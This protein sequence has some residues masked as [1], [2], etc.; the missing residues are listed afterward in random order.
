M[1]VGSIIQ[2][3][4][5]TVPEGYLVCDG[6]AV[7]RND[8]AGL[9]DVIGITFGPGDGSTTFNVPNLS[10]KVAMCLSSGHSLGSTGGESEHTLLEAETPQHYHSVPAHTHADTL[11]AQTP[12]LTHSITA[13]PVMKYTR[14]DGNSANGGAGNQINRYNSRTDKT[15]SIS[16]NMSITAHPATACTM[17]GSITDCPALTSSNTGNGTAHNNMMPYLALTYLIRYAPD[18]PPGPKMAYY[19]GALPVGPLGGYISGIT[20]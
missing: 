20:R 1:E 18:V 3:S 12:S 11:A 10:G 4:G 6:S 9:F 14:L 15:M 7:S 13:Q 16:T 2:Y 8:Y 17:T 19:N 5:L